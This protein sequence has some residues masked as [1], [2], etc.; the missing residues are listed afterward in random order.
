ML[1]KEVRPMLDTDLSDREWKAIRS[2]LPEPKTGGRRRS[3]NLREVVNAVRYMQATGCGYRRL[4][5][6]FPHRSTVWHYFSNWQR[7]G[8]WPRVCATLEHAELA[9]SSH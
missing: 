1:M 6:G 7:A 5:S 3:I 9:A 2:L 8:V 4:P